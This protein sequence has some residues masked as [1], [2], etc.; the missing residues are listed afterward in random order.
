MKIKVSLLEDFKKLDKKQKII[1]CIL[2]LV[3]IFDITFFAIKFN[4]KQKSP[5]NLIFTSELENNKIYALNINSKRG[6]IKKSGYAYYEFSLEQIENLWQ[7]Y[8]QKKSLSL[9]LRIGVKDSRNLSG[10]KFFWGFL[11]NKDFSK[12]GKLLKNLE[13]RVLIGSELNPLLKK[14]WTYFDTSFSVNKNLNKEDF[15]KGFFVYSDYHINIYDVFVD[16]AKIGY[17]FTNTIP[18]YATGANGGKINFNS[19][20]FDFSGA[21]SVFAAKNSLDSVMPYI[22]LMYEPYNKE[23]ENKELKDNIIKI[24]FNGEEISINQTESV[25]KSIIQTSS[26]HNPFGLYEVKTN[27]SLVTKMMMYPNVE[28]LLPENYSKVLTPLVTD[29]GMILESK[30]DSWRCSDY[31]LYEWDRFKGI[32]FFDTKNY[33]IQS[34]F[35]RRLAF[36]VEKAGYKGNIL[37]DEQLGTMH[38]YNAHDY[39]AKSLSD[40]FTKAK[41]SSVKLLDKELLLEQ[42]LIKNNIIIP[43]ENGYKEGIGAVISI[44]Q[45]SKA[46]LR[47]SFIAHES[48]H[49]LFFIDEDF[50]NTTAAIYYTIDQKSIDFLVG[51]WDSQSG[52]QYDPTDTYLMHNE[53]MAY[54]MQ[55]PLSRISSYFVHLANRA[56]VMKAIPDLCKYVRDTNGITFEDAGKIFDSYVYDRW[57]LSCGR[58][59][60]ISRN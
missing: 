39:S 60:L 27:Q 11:Y 16:E 55:Q 50:R 49:G 14:E 36:Y 37:T 4:S 43:T 20:S 53:F 23:L 58:V 45:E 40:F 9:T 12:K 8:K 19:S 47:Q 51:Y 28:S 22:E 54:I 59:S 33:K 30:M 24:N 46:W 5:S 56:S 17:D 13:P 7:L 57:G 42:I 44:S 1:S 26:L 6:S 32:L 48:L 21:T 18:L 25:N 2:V 15:P 31:E 52:L 29:P 3:L 41:A 34:D 38:G 35:F 10:N